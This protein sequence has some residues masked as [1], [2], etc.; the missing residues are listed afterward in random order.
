V[1]RLAFVLAVLLACGG[2]GRALPAATDDGTIVERAP[3]PGFADQTAFDA[4]I[5]AYYEEDIVTAGLTEELAA[6]PLT[7]LFPA[8]DRERFER[9]NTAGRCERV[10]YKSEGLRV[11]GFVVRPETPGPHPVMIYLRGGSGEFGKIENV[12]LLTLLAF[13]DAGFVV[14][15]TQ[16]RGVDGGEGVHEM[17]G[18]ELADVFNL[19]ALAKTLPEANVDKLFLYGGSRGG[20]EGLLALRKGLAVRAAAFRAPM[21]D[22]RAALAHRPDLAKPWKMFVLDFETDRE[23]ALDRLSAIKH[24][25]AL[26]APILLLAGRQDWRVEVK[27]TEALA[28]ALAARKRD[29]KLVIYERE[30]HQLAFHRTEW[31]GEVIAWFKAHGA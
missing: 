20:M 14:V 4:A 18:R 30:E 11:V 12:T 9:A 7:S 26:T 27:T 13:A 6:R 10:I 3:C 8:A 23:A 21:T 17:G 5:K 25:D 24:V 2:G 29:H 16:Y 28:A 31:I 15:A 1:V 19:R 22:A